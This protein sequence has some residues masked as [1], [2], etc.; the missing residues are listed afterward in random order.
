MPTIKFKAKAQDGQLIIDGK[1]INV[2]RYK[3]PELTRNHCDMPA[4]RTCRKYGGYA[5]S[6][7]FLSMLKRELNAI[8]CDYWI[9]EGYI[10]DNVKIDNSG[11]LAVITIEL[12]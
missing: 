1:I 2:T 10:P 8:G 4:F 7:L 11:F 9:N 12:N 6:T 3:V 5:N